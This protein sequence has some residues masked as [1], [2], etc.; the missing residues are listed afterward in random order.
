[1]TESLLN[2]MAVIAGLGL[3]AATTAWWLGSSHLALDRG[4]D[5]TGTAAN[6]LYALL[7]VRGMALAVLSVRVGA[8]RGWRPAVETGLGLIGPS[9]P[10]VLV[11]WSASAA[12]LTRVVLGE[13]VLLAGSIALPLIGVGLRR[14]LGQAELAVMT[15][16]ATGV[17]L[18][19]AIWL[20][21]AAW[22]IPPA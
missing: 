9:W 1:M 2:R 5:A 12:P 18:A 21:R 7:L 20:T 19:P 22:V 14:G 13:A 16:T 17:A 15:G 3:A 6:A 10:V 8:L 11:A 4:M